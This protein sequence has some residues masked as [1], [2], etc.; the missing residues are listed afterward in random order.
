MSKEVSRTFGFLVDVDCRS[1]DELGP[2]CRV[3]RGARVS[4]ACFDMPFGAYLPRFLF[5][6]P[7]GQ[8]VRRTAVLA[9]RFSSLA[10]DSIAA[11]I[12]NP[13]MMVLLEHVRYCW[14]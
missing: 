7:Q 2:S 3:V 8:T 14:L 13:A 5:F 12:V 1:G 6:G 9:A 10:L 4:V 11:V